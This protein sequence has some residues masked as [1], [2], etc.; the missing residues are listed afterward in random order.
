MI[1]NIK[2]KIELR[3]EGVSKETSLIS[4]KAFLNQK[5]KNRLVEKIK[6]LR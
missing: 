1:N 3:N 6:K 2:K 5:K 4:K